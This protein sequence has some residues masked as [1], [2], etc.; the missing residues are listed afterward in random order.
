MGEIP[1][2]LGSTPVAQN[3]CLCCNS[4]RQCIVP[5]TAAP[6]HLPIISIPSFS[7]RSRVVKIHMAAPSPTPLAFPAVVDASPHCG[8]AGFR[9]AKPSNVTPGR[10][11]SSW[12]IVLSPISTGMISSAN[13]PLARLSK[14]HQYDK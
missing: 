3:E 13:M 11:V 9:A 6:I 7:A 12:A 14:R 8:K 10:M 1:I 4:R 2:C 5:T